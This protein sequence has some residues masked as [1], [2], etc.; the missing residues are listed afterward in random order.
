[1]KQRIKLKKNFNVI[2]SSGTTEPFSKKKLYTSIHHTG[3]L[4]KTCKKITDKVAA[5]LDEGF[6]TRDIYRK[7]LNLVRE[8]SPVAAIHYSLKRALFDLG[9]SGHPFENFVGKYFE[10]KGFETKTCQTIQGKF[11]KHEIDVVGTK[12]NQKIFA[13]CKFHN[14][15]GIKNDVKIT[16]Y[17]KARWDDV[18]DGPEGRN[19][20]YFFLASN[21][22]FSLDAIMYAEGSGLQLLGVNAPKEL[23][24]F[25][26]IKKMRLY[27]ITSL[28][29]INRHFKSRLLAS[30]FVLAKELTSQQKLLIQMGMTDVEIGR[31]MNEIQLLVN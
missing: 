14:H 12:D 18:K 30:G 6:K 17:V 10:A 26:E 9:P 19:L 4:P 7:A 13:E 25:D 22:S 8:S 27:P 31:L 5:E 21:T 16:L 29:Q 2:K 15:Q 28:K 20:K 11:V 1:M 24:F 3:L 23:S